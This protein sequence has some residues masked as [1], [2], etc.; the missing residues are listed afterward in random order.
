[1]PRNTGVRRAAIY[2]RYSSTQQEDTSIEDQL[3]MTRDYCQREGYEVVEIYT[4][5]AITGRTKD[6][7]GFLKL[8]A[9]VESGAFDTIV[10][11]AVDRL[12]RN[13]T[14][15]L[16]AWD[17]FKFQG[18]ELRSVTEGP[19]SFFTVLLQGYG[20]QM[21]SEMIG[22]HTK[23]GMQGA[24]SR[25]RTHSSAYGYDIVEDAAP[26]EPNRRINSEQ[27]AVVQRIYQDTAEGLSGVAIARAL[28]T[29]GIP[30]PKGGSWDASTIRGH[31]ARGNGILHNRLYIGQAVIC[32]TTRH[33]HPVTGAK[34]TE[35]TPVEQR[36][37]EIPALRIISDDLWQR[38]RAQIAR[39]ARRVS[40]KA[41]GPNPEAARRNRYL[42][43][44]MMVCGCCGGNYVKASTTSFR[45]NESRK[46]A[47]E[48]RISISRKRIEARVFGRIRDAFRS[49]ELLEAFTEALDAERSKMKDFDPNKNMDHTQQRLSK[50][51]AARKAILDAIEA[52]APF[53]LYKTRS[54]EIESEI[55]DLE[56]SLRQLRARAETAAA[57]TPDAAALFEAAV[58]KMEQLLSD[59]E[60]VD[61]ASQFLGQIIKRVV[62]N[63]D[64]NA[65]H[66][67]SLK[68]ETDFAALLAP[69]LEGLSPAY[70]VC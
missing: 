52:G 45:C 2:A 54:E 9:G 44:G 16:E 63:P 18:V 30:A 62:I 57:A 8:L 37:Q 27:A 53:A 14:H 25:N 3:R 33:Y 40:G 69:E 60:L 32:A 15:T 26:G 1:M 17:L 34:R 5:H 50:A 20:A 21:F 7:P 22:V 51:K 67:L 29:E 46:H 43:S 35:M 13:L 23:R 38:S 48:N 42:L 11:E 41:G 65:Q 36:E 31:A 10:I 70:L 58:V 47:C 61:Q 68:L 55:A 28:N 56:Q 39:A 64:P 4:D 6:R 59:P 19:Q 49:P 66:G 24:L 12:S